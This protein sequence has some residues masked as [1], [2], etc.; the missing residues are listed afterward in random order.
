[1]YVCMYCI[2]TLILYGYVIILQYM[3]TYAH[4]H[5]HICRK[6]EII[7]TLKIELKGNCIAC[8]SGYSKRNSQAQKVIVAKPDDMACSIR[9]WTC[10]DTTCVM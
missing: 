4:T 9:P 3:L 10:E 8:N 5:L 1:M 7:H 6:S 2:I